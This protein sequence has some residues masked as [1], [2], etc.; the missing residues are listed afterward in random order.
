MSGSLQR[1]PS[2]LQKEISMSGSDGQS[3]SSS[4][5][6]SVSVIWRLSRA[7]QISLHA[8]HVHKIAPSSYNLFDDLGIIL[9]DV[10]E[11]V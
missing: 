10:T 1:R 3:H 7:D 2:A 8:S 9:E 4:I 11:T 5:L 6:L